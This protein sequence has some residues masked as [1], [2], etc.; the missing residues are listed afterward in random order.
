MMFT[1]LLAS[2]NEDRV[3]KLTFLLRHQLFAEAARQDGHRNRLVRTGQPLSP[4]LE[5][6]YYLLFPPF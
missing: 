6:K 3:S 1:Y 4:D 5:V 2:A